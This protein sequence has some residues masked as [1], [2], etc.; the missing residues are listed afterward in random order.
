MGTIVVINYG[1]SLLHKV[2]VQLLQFKG[3]IVIRHPKKLSQKMRNCSEI[4][5]FIE[6]AI[7]YF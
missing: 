2:E 6:I 5:F 7:Q 4:K 1:K 3:S